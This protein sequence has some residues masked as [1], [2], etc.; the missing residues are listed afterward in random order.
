MESNQSIVA[1]L[2][3]MALVLAP[4]GAAT[5]GVP[6]ETSSKGIEDAAA[7]MPNTGA[8]LLAHVR[9]IASSLRQ[10][11]QLLEA[12]IELADSA[13]GEGA[14]LAETLTR[15]TKSFF[16]KKV[17]PK[18]QPMLEMEAQAL[19]AIPGISDQIA[20]MISESIGM[21]VGVVAAGAVEALIEQA[22][23]LLGLADDEYEVGDEEEGPDHE[24]HAPD[25]SKRTDK[26]KGKGK[27]EQGKRTKGSKA[28]V[29]PLG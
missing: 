4:P 19:A 9:P 2:L 1:R 20:G 23:E 27:H 10:E 12:A 7:M 25:H 5:R 17:K 6:A 18:I 8:E 28:R 11:V 14:D 24:H 13:G 21:V 3:S 26:K 22:E 29:A 15:V 16:E